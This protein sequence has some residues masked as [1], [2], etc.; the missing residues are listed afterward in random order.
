MKKILPIFILT[1]LLVPFVAQAS[2]FDLFFGRIDPCFTLRADKPAAYGLC[3]LVDNVG[4]V[5]YV[6]GW[7]LAVVIILIGGITYMTSVGDEEKVK[8]AKNIIKN[9]LIG[10]AIVLLAGVILDTLARFLVP[11]FF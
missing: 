9:G 4:T 3:H 6:V 1:F 7:S 11:S 8:K 5:L 2:I 10:A